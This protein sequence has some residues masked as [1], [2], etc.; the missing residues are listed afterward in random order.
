MRANYN[1]WVMTVFQTWVICFSILAEKS[2]VA[3][4]PVSHSVCLRKHPDCPSYLYQRRVQGGGG[5]SSFSHSVKNSGYSGGERIWVR[6][7][8]ALRWSQ[9]RTTPVKYADPTWEC[10]Q[11]TRF[12]R[13]CRVSLLRV[14]WQWM[15]GLSGQDK[16]R[17]SHK[18]LGRTGPSG[19]Y[20]AVTR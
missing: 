11:P 7:Q 3:W 20:P 8:E 6:Q 2:C 15:Q 13:L 1:Y 10:I 12:C 9:Q 17:R 16:I 19:A 5:C 4:H 18:P 14:T